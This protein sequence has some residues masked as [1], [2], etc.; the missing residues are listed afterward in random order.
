MTA[1]DDPY[2]CHKTTWRRHY[3]AARGR[4]PDADDTVLVNTR[5]HAIETTTANLA[6][7]IGGQWYC[8]PLSDGGLPGIGRQAAL[9]QGHLVERSVRAADL[10]ACDELAVINDLSGWRQ[11]ILTA[12][13]TR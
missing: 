4:F 12:P 9:D 2:S 1:A 8:P 11:A 10:A 6:Y 7:R 3:D 5:A 13:P